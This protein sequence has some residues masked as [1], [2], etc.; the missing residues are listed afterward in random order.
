LNIVLDTNVLVRIVTADDPGQTEIAQAAIQAAVEQGG[1]VVLPITALRELAWVLGR[2][3]GA[4]KPAI[5]A[6]IRSLVDSR[7]TLT[8][9]AAVQA[10]MAFLENGGDFA[11]GVILHQGAALGGKEFLSFDRKA[12]A[13]AMAQGRNARLLA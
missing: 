8:D 12:I 5:A 6:A 10:G 7:D 4:R 3:F 9:T 11:D 2:G 1:L 13:L